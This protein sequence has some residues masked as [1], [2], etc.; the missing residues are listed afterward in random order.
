MACSEAA[1]VALVHTVPEDGASQVEVDT[2]IILNFDRAVDGVTVQLEPEVPLE[3][4][5]SYFASGYW[6]V[7]YA[8]R[9][10]LEGSMEYLLSVGVVTPPDLH[11]IHFTTAAVD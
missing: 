8:P 10:E 1:P 9:R 7:V 2:E 3:Q 6:V 5:D 11:E 4:M